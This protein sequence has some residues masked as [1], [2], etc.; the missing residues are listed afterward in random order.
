MKKEELRIGNWY[1]SVKFGVPVRC[2]LSDLY[3]LCVKSDGAYNDPPIDEMFKPISLTEERLIKFGFKEE[4]VNDLYPGAFI[5]HNILKSD[6]Y[7]RPSYRGGYFW[8]FNTP[9]RS[10]QEFYDVR[11]LFY[12]HELQN[13][14]FDLTGEEL[15]TDKL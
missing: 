6:L 9:D 13:L 12:V 3:E 7:L 10:N 14:Y 1:L 4:K 8:G 11:D 5:I 2:E 15:K